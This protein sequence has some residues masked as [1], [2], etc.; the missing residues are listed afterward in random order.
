MLAETRS[1]WGRESEQRRCVKRVR[2]SSARYSRIKRNATKQHNIK[3]ICLHENDAV[4]CRPDQMVANEQ[5]SAQSIVRMPAVVECV[6]YSLLSALEG[7]RGTV[8]SLHAVGTSETDPR[9]ALGATVH[10]K[11]RK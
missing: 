8:R 10:V 2:C 7:I 11:K 6:A 5:I 9:A 4:A 1:D 3:I